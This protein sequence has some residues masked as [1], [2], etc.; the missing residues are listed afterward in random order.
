ME[1]W[2]KTSGMYAQIAWAWYPA[3]GAGAYTTCANT[4]SATYTKLICDFTMPSNAVRL[5]VIFGGGTTSLPVDRFAN[6]DDWYVAPWPLHSGNRRFS[7]YGVK[8]DIIS[9]T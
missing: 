7:G 2:V 6:V 4:N 3:S 8:A 1:A 5:D 9:P